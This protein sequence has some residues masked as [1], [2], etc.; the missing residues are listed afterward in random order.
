MY[1]CFACLHVYLCTIYM[2]GIS[3]GQKKVQIP[4]DWSYRWFSL[5]SLSSL[6]PMC[7]FSSIKS[8]SDIPLN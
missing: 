8:L 4:V 1:G 5:Q 3:G 2:P 6:T 7:V